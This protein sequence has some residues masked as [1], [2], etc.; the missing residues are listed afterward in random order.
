METKKT[1]K[2]GRATR[3]TTNRGVQI[4]FVTYYPKENPKNW[5]E[6]IY[7][8]LDYVLRMNK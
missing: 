7:S 5:E 4:E 3:I 2:K 8:A 1:Y 6:E